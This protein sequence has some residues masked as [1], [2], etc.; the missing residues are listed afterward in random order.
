MNVLA[1]SSPSFAYSTNNTSRVKNR[2]KSYE[3][4][5]FVGLQGVFFKKINVVVKRHEFRNTSVL[6]K[7]LFRCFLHGI[8]SRV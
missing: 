4:F 3:S 5:S 8:F 6:T 2:N 1:T 7:L